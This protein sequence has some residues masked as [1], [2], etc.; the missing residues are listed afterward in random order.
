M[1]DL[2]GILATVVIACL[3]GYAIVEIANPP[4]C[5]GCVEVAP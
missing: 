1:R 3:A 5:V 2:A 4:E